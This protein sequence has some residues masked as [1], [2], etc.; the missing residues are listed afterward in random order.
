MAGLS[1]LL[2]RRS[3]RADS[4]CVYIV[5]IGSVGSDPRLS[6]LISMLFNCN[7][8]DSNILNR[9]IQYVGI[10]MLLLILINRLNIL[11]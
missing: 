6:M 1:K 4:H 7:Q 9:S 3:E 10:G 5:Y 2:R 11:N 8:Y